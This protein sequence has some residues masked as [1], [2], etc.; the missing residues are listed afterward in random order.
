MRRLLQLLNFGIVRKRLRG[1]LHQVLP[2]RLAKGEVLTR[3]FLWRADVSVVA[4]VT[5]DDVEGI[6]VLPHPIRDAGVIAFGEIII[7]SLVVEQNVNKTCNEIWVG[8]DPLVGH[9]PAAHAL[10][11]WQVRLPLVRAV[12]RVETKYL[13][14]GGRRQNRNA[15]RIETLAGVSRLRMVRDWRL[16]RAA[17]ANDERRQA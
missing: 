13:D 16:A 2:S 17:D 5:D 8:I 12:R 7:K 1:D 4:H 11:T 3:T 9:K 15:T 6:V 14:L 10:L